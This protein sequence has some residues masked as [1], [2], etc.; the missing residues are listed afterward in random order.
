[1]LLE[2]KVDRFML[3]GDKVD[4]PILLGQTLDRHMLLLLWRSVCAC[5]KS[6]SDCDNADSI[7]SFKCI[8]HG[9]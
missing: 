3:L 5:E 6:M 1:M 8:L 7:R 9:T 4:I 2:K